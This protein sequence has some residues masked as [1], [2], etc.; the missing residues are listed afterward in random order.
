[1]IEFQPNNQGPLCMRV[2]R[3]AR[4]G[5]SARRDLRGG[6]RTTGVPTSIEYRFKASG[7]NI[8]GWDNS[9]E[10]DFAG[11]R[12]VPSKR[13]KRPILNVRVLSRG[14]QFNNLFGTGS[15]PPGGFGG[16]RRVGAS[17]RADRR[18]NLPS[19]AARVHGRLPL[20]A[21]RANPKKKTRTNR[22]YRPASAPQTRTNNAPAAP[23]VGLDV[24]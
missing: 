12:A 10:I 20:S 17:Y 14:D 2:L 16:F 22:R 15:M 7:T 1:M 9:I 6:R 21:R 24:R 11:F 19:T 4:C 18:A 5:S 8:G 23:A 3:G 13:R